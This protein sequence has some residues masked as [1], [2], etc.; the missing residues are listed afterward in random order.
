MTGRRVALGVAA[1]VLLAEPVGAQ[2]FTDWL[3][4]R[5]D[6][7][8]AARLTQRGSGRQTEAPSIARSSTALVDHPAFADLVGLALDLLPTFGQD[9]DTER[10]ATA[11]TVTPYTVLTAL[12][13]LDPDDPFVY[14]RGSTW[15]S[16]ALTLGVESADSAMGGEQAALVGLKARLWSRQ[17]VDPG[18]ERVERLRADLGMAGAAF[19]DLSA[20]LQDSLFAWV[21]QEEGVTR[22]TFINRLEE[23]DSLRSWLDRAGPE[24][25]DVL[26]GLVAARVDSFVRLRSAANDVV[27]ELRSAPQLA[28]DVQSRLRWSGD[29]EVRVGL[30]LDLGLTSRARWTVNG[31]ATL[32]DGADG[33]PTTGGGTLASGLTLDLGPDRMAGPDPLALDL[34][35]AAEFLNRRPPTWSLQGKMDVPLVEGVSLPVSVTWASRTDLVDESDVL[36]RVG[37]TVDTSRLL[38]ALEGGAA[39]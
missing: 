2:G 24:R 12:L 39:P 32:V 6:E 23:P 38:A 25:V 8:V 9:G 30:V 31:S 3:N 33:G 16:V 34:A 15:R 18:S 17:T 13:G 19:G 10:P 35:F 27:E 1:L 11:V 26:L 22:T 37:F 4:A 28:L 14:R 5:V 29:D 20:A 36:G 21:G 7:A